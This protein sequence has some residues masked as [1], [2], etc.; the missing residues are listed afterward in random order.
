MTW[1][2]LAT[3]LS[4]LPRVLAGPM[5]R[6]VTP[7]SVTVWFALRVPAKITIRVWAGDRQILSGD[8]TTCAVGRNLHIVAVTA[9]FLTPGMTGL[10]EGAIYCYDAV[11]DFKNGESGVLLPA[12]T[13]NA[14][15]S[16]GTLGM[17]SFSLPPRDLGR[18]RLLQGS[19]RRP[20]SGSR[21]ML[22]FL[23][24][25]IEAKADKPFERPHQLL[26]TGDQIYAD[27]VSDPLRLIVTDAADALLGWDELLPMPRHFGDMLAARDV[28]GSMRWAVLKVAGFTSDDLRSHLMSLGEYLSMYLLVWS[29]VLWPT[30]LPRAQ[31]RQQ[32]APGMPAVDDVRRDIRANANGVLN[33]LIAARKFDLAEQFPEKTVDAAADTD[34]IGDTL[35]QLALFQ[36]KLVET[37]RA[38]ANVPSYMIFDDHEIT[39]DWNMTRSFCN[40]VW[41]STPRATAMTGSSY[42]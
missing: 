9:D 23:D 37:R 14:S 7:M 21:D 28:H 39:D 24:G 16:Y 3:R 40:D 4:T 10:G 30:L 41:S 25:M 11:F 13:G 27:D 1:N 34:W 20:Y 22:P 36:S 32:G 35:F 5:L 42:R 31:W 19:C 38:L 26:L 6:K 8:G 17:P 33:M 2:G 18:L 12:A 15:L 29:P